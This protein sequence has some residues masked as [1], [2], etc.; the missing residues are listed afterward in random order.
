MQ[1]P[2]QHLIDDHEVA[3]LGVQCLAAMGRQVE[4][5]ARFPAED[6]A[7]ALRFLREWVVAVHMRKEDSLLAPAV[8]MRGDDDSAALVGELMRLHDEIDELLQSLVLFWEPLG[9]LTDEEQRGFAAAVDALIQRLRRRQQL[10][11]QQLFPACERFVGADD[12]L[13]WLEEFRELE[14]ERGRRS[15]WAERIEALASRW[16]D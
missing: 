12:Q 13:S 11:E 7:T 16:L 5:G 3:A 9:K 14:D 6:V 1:R 10:E 4:A 15:E 8:A 2:T